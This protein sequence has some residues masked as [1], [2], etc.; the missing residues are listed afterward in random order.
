VFKDKSKEVNLMK[1]R[2]GFTLIE[3]LVVISVI[4][5]LMAILM[6]S[7]SRAREQARSV[8]CRSNLRQWGIAST[9]FAQEN[10]DRLVAEYD[11]GIWHSAI[12]PYLNKK[13]KA[14]GVDL[15]ADST[16]KHSKSKEL[17]LCPS[18]N[19]P[20]WNMDGSQG[21]GFGLGP[22]SAW[23]RWGSNAGDDWDSTNQDLG[24]SNFGLSGFAG[25]YAFNAWMY[26]V[27]FRDEDQ[28]HQL[29]KQWGT[30]LAKGASKIPLIGA[31][32]HYVAYPEAWD[33]PPANEVGAEY[34]GLA[35]YAVNR[36]HGSVN[37]AFLDGSVRKV[38]L[39]ELW[40]QNLKWHREW[41][42]DLATATSRAGIRWPDWMKGF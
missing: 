35:S 25:S 41:T 30:F 17:S 10:D 22:K 5:V 12:R 27:T 3:L 28:G 26:K 1:E 34:V 23:G 4:A 9:M 29:K 42:G 8:A 7:L 38:R 19:K 39:K 36:H 21:P 32:Y 18:A 24:T 15:H 2:R 6:P 40:S 13:T 33:A 20:R 31:N 14:A 37:M 16:S 11:E